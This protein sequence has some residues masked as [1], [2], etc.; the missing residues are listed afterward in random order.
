M[1]LPAQLPGQ[2]QGSE[3]GA[4]GRVGQAVMARGG[5]GGGLRCRRRAECGQQCAAAL[6][7]GPRRPPGPSALPGPPWPPAPPGCVGRPRRPAHRSWLSGVGGCGSVPGEATHSCVPRPCHAQLPTLR[8]PPPILW[9]LGLPGSPH[10][11]WLC[12][13]SLAQDQGP[14]GLPDGHLIWGAQG[15]VGQ[16]VEHQPP[17]A[18]ARVL[19]PCHQVVQQ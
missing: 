1:A 11:L 2:P 14:R 3:G 17:H 19:L 4:R 6:H 12:C 8:A 9:L 16:A 10:Q 15:D 13:P 18:G 5:W 7:V